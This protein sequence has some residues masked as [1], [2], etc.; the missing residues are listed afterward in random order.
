VQELNLEGKR[1]LLIEDNAVNLM[2]ATFML[3][4]YAC[5]IT[6]AENGVQAVE[7]IKQGGFDLVLMDCQM[8]EMDGYEATKVVRQLEKETAGA[9]IPIVALTANAMKGDDEKCFAAGMDDYITKPIEPE[10]LEN[11]LRKWLKS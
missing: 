6:P 11:I 8:P 10:K 2:M 5:H 4:K 7:L 1:L 9:H 3:E